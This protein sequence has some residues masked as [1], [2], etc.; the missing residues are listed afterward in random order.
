MA[1][2][3][4][5]ALIYKNDRNNLYVANCFVKNIIGMGKTETDA[6]LNL[7]KS[8]SIISPNVLVKVKPMY[9]LKMRTV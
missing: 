4:Y 2:S 8:L 6:I 1:C 9:E 5:P 7:E 3:E